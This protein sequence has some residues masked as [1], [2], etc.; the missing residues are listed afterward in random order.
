MT[1]QNVAQTLYLVCTLRCMSRPRFQ[2]TAHRTQHLCQFCKQP[3]SQASLLG[4]WKDLPPYLIYN[5]VTANHK[6]ALLPSSL[7]AMHLQKVGSYPAMRPYAVARLICKAWCQ[8]VNS[9]MQQLAVSSDGLHM[10]PQFT[11]LCE[12]SILSVDGTPAQ[13]WGPLVPSIAPQLTRLEVESECLSDQLCSVIQHLSRLQQLA[14]CP[15]AGRLVT[16]LNHP[17]LQQLQ[18]LTLTACSPSSWFGADLPES[19]MLADMQFDNLTSLKTLQLHN[20]YLVSIPST[21][22]KLTALTCLE[23]TGNP[24]LQLPEAI[25]HLTQLQVCTCV[26]GS[27]VVLQSTVSA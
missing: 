26:V 23:L 10:V 25:L 17:A 11:A 4:R 24:Y 27:H 21:I 18:Q 7:P 6:E 22:S 8:A 5:I 13:G 16:W 15:Q 9:G 19:D 3:D 12:L 20:C 14:C 1:L 2:T